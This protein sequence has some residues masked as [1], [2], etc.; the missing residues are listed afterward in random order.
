[1]ILNFIFS[2]ILIVLV[3]FFEVVI[4]GGSL[5]YILDFPSFA[6]VFLIFAISIILSGCGKS[7]CT[8]F[9]SRKKFST[10]DFQH[11]K[12]SDETLAFSINLL[13]YSAIFIPVLIIIYTLSNITKSP[14]ILSHLGS[15]CAVLLLSLLYLSLLEMI[16]I[17]IKAKIR[18]TSVLFMAENF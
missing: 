1:M 6:G 5:F 3:T 7:F 9:S 17:T 10:F 11:L 16:L 4:S 18:K 13:F 15:N 2:L 8:I 14:D 12:K